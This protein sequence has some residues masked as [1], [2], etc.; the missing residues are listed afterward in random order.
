MLYSNSKMPFGKLKG[1]TLKYVPEPYLI[2][3]YKNHFDKY[4]DLDKNK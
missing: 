1:T 4:D 3:F 2:D